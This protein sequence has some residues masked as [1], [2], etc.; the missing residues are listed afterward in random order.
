MLIKS[1]SGIRGIFPEDLS[2]SSLLN[3][4]NALAELH[5]GQIVLGRDTRKSGKP[6]YELVKPQLLIYGCDVL[7]AGIVPT[8]TL[9]YF[10]KK[11]GSSAG[12]QITAS[13]N[14]PEWNGLKFVNKH[15][16]FFGP[17]EWNEIY[18][19]HSDGNYRPPKQGRTNEVD[20]ASHHINA[21]L[22]LPF[23]NM[24]AVKSSDIKVVYDGNGGAGPSIILPLLEKLQVKFVPVGCGLDGNFSHPP[25]PLPKNISTVG[26]FV[27][28]NKADLGF[29]TDPDGDRL[30]LIDES[31]NPIGEEFTLALSALTVLKKT[32]GDVVK[33][34]ST[35]SLVDFV[36]QKFG[37]RVIRTPVGEYWVSKKMLEVGAIIGGEGN[38]G[39]ILPAFH[40]VRDAATGV[41][42]ILSLLAESQKSLSQIISE[43]PQFFMVKDKVTFHGEFAEI[44]PAIECVFKPIDKDLSDGLWMKLQDGWIH[45]RKSNTEPV[46]RIISESLVPETARKNADIVMEILLTISKKD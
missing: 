6:I 20:A 14:P 17:D 30:A 27:S 40:P 46:V 33:N 31:G 10:T 34:L 24:D 45:I 15:G 12:I 21:I 39:V 38:G 2:P 44:I 29:S 18:S 41:A 5:K 11:S 8:P 35:S 9:A 22:D 25:E 16:F 43:F 1:I 7:S 13:H 23:V 32:K 36:A 19:Y 26:R 3:F 4:V 42:L 37:V 28:E